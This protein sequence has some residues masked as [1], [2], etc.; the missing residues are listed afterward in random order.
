MPENPIAAAP[1]WAAY[2]VPIPLAGGEG[3]MSLPGP[4]DPG[5][6]LPGP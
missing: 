3:Y 5:P 4:S 2:S 6:S 1:L